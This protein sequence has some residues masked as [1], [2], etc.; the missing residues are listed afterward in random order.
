MTVC[1]DVLIACREG[2]FD[3]CS[4]L[5]PLIKRYDY[6]IVWG[7]ASLLLSRAGSGKILRQLVESFAPEIF[8]L[9]DTFVQQW[10]SET[11]LS[12]GLSWTVPVALNIM[13]VQTDREKEFSIPTYLSFLLE[14]ERGL[15]MDGPDKI[16]EDGWPEWYDAPFH[17][18]DEGYV[19]M[20]TARHTAVA[21]TL[22]NPETDAI[23][24][25]SPL[26][27]DKIAHR[28]L[29]LVSERRDVEEVV[30]GRSMLEA[31]TGFDLTAM[32]KDFLLDPIAA[33]MT[34]EEFFD[35]VDLSRFVTGQR[36]FFGHQIP[37]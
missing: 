28:T 7:A 12:S 21:S 34:M 37:D 2:R 18:D 25:G 10:V 17:Y 24:E 27:F 14:S 1:E 23:F 26:D 16:R 29:E 36:Y 11:L 5:I 33:G 20:V 22:S 30:I 35:E 4:S 19:A 3:E 9:R 13:K 15:I 8:H 6:G 32:Y 31:A